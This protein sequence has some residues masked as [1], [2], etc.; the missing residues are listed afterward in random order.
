[1]PHRVT[2][3]VPV[4]RG[5][6]FLEETLNS[7]QAQT[8]RD[9]C[10][11]ISID[12]P[13]QACEEICR[14]FLSDPR[15]SLIVQPERQGWV[16][17]INWL[18]SNVNSEFWCF[19][20]QDDITHPTYVHVLVDAID[21]APEAALVYCDVLPMGRVTEP[22]EQEASVLGHTPFLR[23]I[24]MLNNSLVAFA[25]RGL[26]RREALQDA[27]PI[28]TNAVDDYGADTSWL[29]GV[30]RWGE[31]HRIPKG[32]YW[33]RYHDQNTESQWWGWPQHE[34]RA[35]WVHHC[36]DMLNQ[37]LRVQAT[38]PELR[39]LWFAALERLT[40]VSTARTMVDLSGLSSSEYEA[41][42]RSFLSLVESSR[43]H[44]VPLMLDTNWR[45][46]RRWSERVFWLPREVPAK[47][48]AFG[49]QSITPHR[50]FNVQPDGSSAVWLRTSHGVRPDTIIRLGDVELHTVIKGTL[51]T[52]VVPASLLAQQAG[53]TLMLVGRQ[54]ERRSNV[55][56]LEV[57]PGTE[58]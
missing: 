51:A 31:L 42:L 54:G 14:P 28:A 11:L 52:G 7:I 21:A 3:G 26:T 47:I 50:P 20:Q 12:G 35:A 19:Y 34:R 8:Y 39:L 53:L 37:A 38:I 36:V 15:F 1:M 9:F 32:L 46:L 2:I 56:T 44:D 10:V 18:L 49:P 27:G 43:G 23:Q 24:A 57:K 40:S 33:K 25:F 16:G 30:A 17:N 4:Y 22:F 48:V 13:D 5:E 6:R 29:A 41:M 58:L 45:S 55:V